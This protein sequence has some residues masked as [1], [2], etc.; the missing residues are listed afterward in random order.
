MTL[1]SFS[2]LRGLGWTVATYGLS[3]LLR[4]VT[5]IGLARLLTPEIFGAMLIIASLRTGLDLISDLGIGQ[6]IVQSNDAEDPR[7]YTTAWTLQIIRGLILWLVCTLAASPLAQLY[8]SPLLRIAMPIAAFYFIFIGCTS[9][10]LYLVQKRLRVA[11]LNGFDIAMDAVASTAV[12]AFAYLHPSVLSIIIGSLV[13]T[14]TRMIAS[15]FLLPDIRH[16]FYISRRYTHQIISFG[17]WI[18]ISSIVYFLSTTFDRLY[19]GTVIPLALLGI[20]GIARTLS[21]LMGGLA[22]RLA[23]L[24][25]FPLIASS[26]HIPKDTLRRRLASIRFRFMLPTAVA[27]SFFVSTADLLIAVLYDSRYRAAGWMVSVLNIGVWF[28]IICNLNGSVLLGFG[29]PVYGAAGSIVKFMCILVGLPFGLSTYGVLGAVI[30]IA[31]S[32]FCRYFPILYGQLRERF[33]FGTQDLVATAVML[34]SMAILQYV[35]WSLNLGTSFD[36]LP[37]INVK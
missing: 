23:N 25:I 32:D 14:A 29:K 4:L 16:T 19:L 12:V 9:I 10:S 33:S 7:F 20:Y 35:R 36:D 24:I 17:K 13:A 11:L 3:Q 8:D 21:D 37:T 6:N 1:L 22:G 15:Y 30:V 31:F 5:N 34:T 2:L 26:S 28:A 27:F 18:F